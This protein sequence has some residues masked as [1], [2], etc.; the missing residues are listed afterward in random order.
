[1]QVLTEGAREAGSLDADAIA[2]ALRQNTLQT[3]LDGLRY[4]PD[5]DLEE[6]QIWIY[7]VEGGEFKQIQW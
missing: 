4:Q 2:E 3:L 7:Q 1:M 6:A 5:G